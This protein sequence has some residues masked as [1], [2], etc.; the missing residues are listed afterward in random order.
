MGFHLFLIVERMYKTGILYV[1]ANSYLQVDRSTRLSLLAILSKHPS[2]KN[3]PCPTISLSKVLSLALVVAVARASSVLNHLSRVLHRTT[4]VPS[5][6][7]L[8]DTCSH[9][10]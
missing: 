1:R 3:T 5:T 4:P 2:T 7:T 10:W 8:D 6:Y 9:E